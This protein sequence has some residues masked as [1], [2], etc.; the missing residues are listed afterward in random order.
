MN[1]TKYVSGYYCGEY[2]F[3]AFAFEVGNRNT[4]PVER[5]GG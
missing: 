3:T 5:L 2:L 1:Y 4:E